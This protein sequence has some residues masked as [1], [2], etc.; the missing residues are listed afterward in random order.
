MVVYFIKEKALSIREIHIELY[1]LCNDNVYVPTSLGWPLSFIS[2]YNC[3]QLIFTSFYH[4]EIIREMENAIFIFSRVKKQ[5]QL[6]LFRFTEDHQL[7]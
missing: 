4:H 3:S 6:R 7:I 5:F 1:D 2:L